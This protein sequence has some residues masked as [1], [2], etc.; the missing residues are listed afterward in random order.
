MKKGSSFLY[1]ITNPFSSNDW[2]LQIIVLQRQISLER[3][4]SR[5]DGREGRA[6]VVLNLQEYQMTILSLPRALF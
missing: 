6:F 5:K 3:L 1:A 4:Q 2:K